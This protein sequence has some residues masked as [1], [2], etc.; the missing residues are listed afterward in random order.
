ME[1]FGGNRCTSGVF[2]VVAILAACSGR[3]TPSALPG[4][5]LSSVGRGMHSMSSTEAKASRQDLLYVSNPSNGTVYVYSYPEGVLMETLSNL[6]GVGGECAE[7][8][9]DVFITTAYQSASSMIYEYAHGGTSPI[10]SLSDPGLANGCSVDPITGNLAVTNPTD[11]Q[12]PYRPYGGDLA[13]YA[14][15]R[16]KPT[17]YYD[18]DAEVGDFLFCGYDASGTLY[19]SALDEYGP[20]QS[21]LLRLRKGSSAFEIINLSTK[22]FG[23]AS[24]Q[25]DG[26]HVTASSFPESGRGKLLVYRLRI[27]GTSATVIGTTALSSMKNKYRGQ[28]WIQSNMIIGIDSPNRDYESISF[29]RYPKGGNPRQKIKKISSELWGVTISLAPPH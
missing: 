26:K 19:L 5:T 16:G 10:G 22:L 12:N 24:V 13:V 15:A 23:L 4:G 11:D 1:F 7:S 21:L 18:Q 8:S 27:S 20:T 2:A 3:E 25:W 6:N 28:T 9:G 14:G 17:M 29:W